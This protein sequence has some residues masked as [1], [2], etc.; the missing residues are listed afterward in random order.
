MLKDRIDELEEKDK[1]RQAQME[2]FKEEL[3]RL[4]SGGINNFGK[5]LTQIYPG[6]SIKVDNKKLTFCQSESY[7]LYVQRILCLILIISLN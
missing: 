1:L 3:M 7:G 6:S 5:E 4:R 2:E